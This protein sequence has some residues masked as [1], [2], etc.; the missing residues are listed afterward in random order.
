[1]AT[2][3]YWRCLSNTRAPTPRVTTPAFIIPNCSAPFSTTTPLEK[4]GVVGAKKT[5]GGIGPGKK[6]IRQAKNRRAE[7]TRKA[8]AP[9]ERKAIRK[10]IVL[11]N[12]NAFEVEG[13]QDLSADSFANEASLGTIVGLP[14]TTVD[15]LRAIE[16]FKTSQGWGYFARPTTL[17]RAETLELARHIK[18][19]EGTTMRR[20]LVG[21]RGSGK[22]VLAL[23]AQSMAFLNGWVV[24]HIPEGM[25]QIWSLDPPISHT[26]CSRINSPRPHNRTHHLR[27]SRRHQPRPIH[28][29]TIHRR[30]PLPHR[31][32]QRRR[33]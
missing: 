33:P 15:S 25:S 5:V 2:Q 21:E 20:L 16:A 28:P 8:P 23:Q 7:P 4:G 27:P 10:R 9:G 17:V 31:Q 32:S 30:A 18:N 6:A 3:K 14:G 24:I 12:T 29:K 22:S 13:V 1:M 19:T 26:D 11:S